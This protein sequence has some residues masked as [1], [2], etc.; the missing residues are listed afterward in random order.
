MLYNF[1]KRLVSDHLWNRD[2]NNY[3]PFRT[4]KQKAEML[5]LKAFDKMSDGAFRSMAPVTK[6]P[7]SGPLLRSNAR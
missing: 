5:K 1:D 6:H 4:K 2:Y 7:V 3:K